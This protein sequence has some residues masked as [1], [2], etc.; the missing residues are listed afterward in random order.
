M[1]KSSKTLSDSCGICEGKKKGLFT[2]VTSTCSDIMMV[3]VR[4]ALQNLG[5]QPFCWYNQYVF[6]LQ[7]ATLELLGTRIVEALLEIVVW[8]N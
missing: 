4:I 5:R 3:T 6:E 1:Q 7:V 2:S 8:Q